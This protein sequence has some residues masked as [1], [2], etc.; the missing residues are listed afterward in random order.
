MVS[1][2]KAEQVEDDDKKVLRQSLV[3]T[4]AEAKVQAHLSLGTG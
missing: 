3:K 4:D 2:L 1:L